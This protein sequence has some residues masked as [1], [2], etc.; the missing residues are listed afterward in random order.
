MKVEGE[1][2]ERGASEPGGGPGKGLPDGDE[3]AGGAE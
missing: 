3:G 2:T 1:G